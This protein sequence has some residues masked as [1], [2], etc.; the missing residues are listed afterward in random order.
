MSRKDTNAKDTM[1]MVNVYVLA[2]L[3]VGNSIVLLHRSSNVQFG[4]DAWCLPGGKV[5]KG[6][7]ARYAIAREVAEEVALAIP[8]SDFELVHIMHR[9]GTETEFISLCFKVDITHLMPKN[10]EPDKHDDMRFFD[11]HQI[12]ET[13]LPAHK[14]IIE[15]IER[16]INY[17]EH[18]W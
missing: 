9:K 15:C 6:E 17:S 10:N 2:F 13:I 12:P 1:V 18:G 3:Y 11:V 4:A 7:T 5:E 14:Q 8:E 16:G